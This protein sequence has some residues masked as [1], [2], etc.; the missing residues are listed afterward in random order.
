[1]IYCYPFLKFQSYSRFVR[2][3]RDILRYS[4]RLIDTINFVVVIGLCPPMTRWDATAPSWIA[5]CGSRVRMAHRHRRALTARNAPTAISAN[6]TIRNEAMYRRKRLRNGLRNRP[7]ASCSKSRPAVLAA[8]RPPTVCRLR[9][10]VCRW[11]Q[12]PVPRRLRCRGRNRLHQ[13]WPYRRN[14]L[15]NVL[16]RRKSFT[17][18]IGRRLPRRR[19]PSRLHL[20]FAWSH[21]LAMNLI[22]TVKC[23]VSWRW[24]QC[25]IHVFTISLLRTHHRQFRSTLWLPAMHLHRSRSKYTRSQL[26]VRLTCSGS[27]ARLIRSWIYT[28]QRCPHRCRVWGIHSTN[29]VIR[30]L[31]R[32]AFNR[33]ATRGPRVRRA[34]QLVNSTNRQDFRWHRLP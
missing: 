20:L 22:R 25:A 9:P 19:H 24:I 31:R 13:P 10:W 33:L 27:T 3:A 1:M 18:R 30:R 6:T 5:S 34:F 11:N 16:C 28:D 15:S 12:Q 32:N 4:A 2:I 26:A 14:W 21:L 29:G 23:S 17:H 7:N 8:G